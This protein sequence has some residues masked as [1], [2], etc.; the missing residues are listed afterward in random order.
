MAKHVV[1]NQTHIWCFLW[2][3]NRSIILGY[4]QDI[5]K[6]SIYI[7]KNMLKPHKNYIKM[8]RETN[9]MI[10]NHFYNKFN[11]EYQNVLQTNKTN[12]KR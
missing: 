10:W 5:Q 9:P 6:K 3:A 12:A 11:Y 4:W 7:V 2:I 1:L 8:I